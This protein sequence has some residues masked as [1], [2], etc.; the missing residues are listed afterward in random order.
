MQISV[1]LAHPNPGSFNHVIAHAA[2]GALR[3]AGHQVHF[4]DLHA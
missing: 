1:I 4:H 2:A 3:E